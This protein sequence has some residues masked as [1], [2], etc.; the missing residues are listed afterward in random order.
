[1]V[2]C[3]QSAARLHCRV[4]EPTSHKP[5]PLGWLAQNSIA[6]L[7][8]RMAAQIGLQHNSADGLGHHSLSGNRYFVPG[9]SR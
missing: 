2:E 3:A 4:A 7:A 1:M 9:E 6:E 5:L 8:L